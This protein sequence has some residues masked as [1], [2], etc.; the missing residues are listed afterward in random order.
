LALELKDFNMYSQSHYLKIKG[1]QYVF[2]KSL[3]KYIGGSS[4]L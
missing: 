4:D 3:L 1:F 2:T